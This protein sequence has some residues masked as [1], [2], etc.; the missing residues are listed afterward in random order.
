MGLWGG[1]VLSCV[2]QTNRFGSVRG[3]KRKP[4]D[5]PLMFAL[6]AAFNHPT[7]KKLQAT[8]TGAFIKL[9]HA[10]MNEGFDPFTA[11]GLQLQHFSQTTPRQ[12]QTVRESVLNALREALPF[13]VSEYHLRIETRKNRIKSGTDNLKAYRDW[14]AKN[15]TQKPVLIVER[16]AAPVI[17]QPF[18]APRHHNEKTDMQ[19]RQIAKA[20]K[21]KGIVL[22]D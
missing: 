22:H 12:W 14:K 17:L 7:V 1:V 3:M 11:S 6:G 13:A 19:A 4:L 16:S 20:N 9:A 10:A 18:K 21:N 2:T 8:Q 15:K 5:R